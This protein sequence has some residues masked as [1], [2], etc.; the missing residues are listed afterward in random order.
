MSVLNVISVAPVNTSDLCSIGLGCAKVN[1]PIYNWNI[2]LPKVPKPPVKPPVLPQV[3]FFKKN[4]L[5]SSSS[6]HCLFYILK[7]WIFNDENFT[8][9][10]HSRGF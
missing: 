1:N 10:R 5:D 3:G 7:A 6:I 9:I 2:T 8:I 4:E